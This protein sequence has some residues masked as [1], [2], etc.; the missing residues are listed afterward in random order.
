M[1]S[2]MCMV[3]IG[4]LLLPTNRTS[5]LSKVVYHTQ[6]INQH[7]DGTFNF[8]NPLAYSSEVADNETYTFKEILQQP[9]KNE[10]IQVM[11]K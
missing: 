4:S 8:T 1:V 9:D 2:M 11:L 7:F 3:T 6:L 5:M 10:Y